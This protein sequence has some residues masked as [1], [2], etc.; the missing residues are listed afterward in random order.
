MVLADVGLMSVRPSILG[1][2]AVQ[3]ALQNSTKQM[4]PD[5]IT[6][7]LDCEINYI[8]KSWRDI[9]QVLFTE[10]ADFTEIENFTAEVCERLAYINNRHGKKCTTLFKP[11]V[12]QYLPRYDAQ[13]MDV[14][15]SGII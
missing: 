1:A 6:P 11:K 13:T 12:T 8:I 5:I 4:R 14:R 10:L 9:S 7:E 3:F 15:F 2:L